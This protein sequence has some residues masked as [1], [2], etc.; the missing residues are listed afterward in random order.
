MKY[1]NPLLKQKNKNNT[2]EIQCMMR[3]QKSGSKKERGA[4]SCWDES[5]YAWKN[6]SLRVLPS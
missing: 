1:L 4:E 3:G 5:Y 6:S 2:V